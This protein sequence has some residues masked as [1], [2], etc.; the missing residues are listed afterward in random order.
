MAIKNQW[1]PVLTPNLLDIKV[2][3]MIRP[4]KLNTLSAHSLREYV[5][6]KLLNSL[7]FHVPIYLIVPLYIIK[8][9][10]T[11]LSADTDSIAIST[12]RTLGQE[13]NN[14]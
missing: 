1:S 7:S 14:V 11:R 8:G 5:K 9:G 12:V 4:S 3:G 6:R 10:R 13:S 2:K